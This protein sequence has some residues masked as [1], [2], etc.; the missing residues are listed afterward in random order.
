MS[1]NRPLS[2]HLSIYKK[3]LPAVF[4]IFH[5]FTGIGMSIGTLLLSIWIILIALGPNYFSIFQFISSYVIF[6]VFLFFWTMAIFYHLFNGIRYL[7]WSYG[8]MMELD[9]VYKSAYIVLALS[10]LSTLFVWLSV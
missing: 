5:R 7:I 6:K 9:A 2:P 4:S 1:L 8:K 10:I 3:V